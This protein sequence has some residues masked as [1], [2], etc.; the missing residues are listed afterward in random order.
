MITIQIW[1]GSGEPWPSSSFLEK[2][3]DLKM[4]KSMGYRMYDG[5]FLICLPYGDKQV[6]LFEKILQD[7]K[8]GRVPS[9]QAGSLKRAHYSKT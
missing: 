4:P 3:R 7:E 1:P 5:S 2:A 8:F 9:G 6:E